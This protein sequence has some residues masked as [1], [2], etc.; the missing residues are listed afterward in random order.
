ME[1]Y[2]KAD[3]VPTLLTPPALETVLKGLH[4]S[5]IRY[6]IQN[7]PPAGGITAWIDTGRW[8]ERETFYG[9]MFGDQRVWPASEL[10][11]AWLHETALCLFPDSPYAKSHDTQAPKKPT[12]PAKN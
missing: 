1:T 10:L 4:D 5:E 2:R 7:D 11:A 12:E 6:G 9:S 3:S 8:T